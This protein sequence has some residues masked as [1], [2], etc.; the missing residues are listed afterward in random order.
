MKIRLSL[1][2]DKDLLR[3]MK[4]YATGNRRAY[5]SWWNIISNALHDPTDRKHIIALTDKLKKPAG[6]DDDADLK[7]L[8]YNEHC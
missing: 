7:A 6:V 3:C 2:I 5:R 1:T 4:T 8:Y